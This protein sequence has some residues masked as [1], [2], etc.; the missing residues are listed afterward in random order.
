[1]TDERA[2]WDGVTRRSDYR[3]ELVAERDALADA[4]RAGDWPAV[5]ARLPS[6]GANATRVGGASGFAPLH[7]A[8][9]HGAPVAVAQELVR[10]GG[11]LTLRATDGRRPV[12]IALGHGHEHLRAVLTPRPRHP[13][14][15]DVLAGLEV[16][17][18]RLVWQRIPELAAELRMRLPQLAVLTELAEPAL[19]FP[20]PGL[21]GGFSIVLRDTELEVKSWNRIAGGWGATHRVTRVGVELVA[22]GWD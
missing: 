20:V 11:W 16:Q 19:W 3:A 6:L 17:L 2:R 10:R 4:A 5:L 18:H 21:Y 7:Q 15:A 22:S 13:L 12:D 9:W 14:P 8:A 1:M